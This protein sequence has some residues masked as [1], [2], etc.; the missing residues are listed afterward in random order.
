MEV[1]G[2]VTDRERSFSV[3]VVDGSHIPPMI[4]DEAR[5]PADVKPT[6]PIAKSIRHF[7]SEHPDEVGL[8]DHPVA[9]VLHRGLSVELTKRRGR[10]QGVEV[11]V[12]TVHG[13]HTPLLS[14]LEERRF[15]RPSAAQEEDRIRRGDHM[16]EIGEGAIALV[17]GLVV[18]CSLTVEPGEDPVQNRSGRDSSLRHHDESQRRQGSHGNATP[19]FGRAF[20]RRQPPFPLYPSLS[21]PIL[22]WSSKEGQ[23]PRQPTSTR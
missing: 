17:A 21:R 12:Q 20:N 19:S 4:L 22:P 10:V 13:D 6:A 16:A 14:L 5:E 1:P 15:L 18:P 23:G 9:A 11:V 8:P 2:G 3:A 7:G